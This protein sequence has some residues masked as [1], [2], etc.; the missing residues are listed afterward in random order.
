MIGFVAIALAVIVAVVVFVTRGPHGT[1][2][3]QAAANA[4]L[5]ALRASDAGR[6]RD[7]AD[8]DHDSSREIPDRLAELGG[9]RLSSVTTSI[10][11]TESDVIRAADFTGLLN[12]Q[13]YTDVLWLYRHSDRWFVALGPHRHPHPKQT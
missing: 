1:A 10:D 3:P 5:T 7:I 4:Y 11:P 8:P 12:G 9:D 13:P 2:S 6:L